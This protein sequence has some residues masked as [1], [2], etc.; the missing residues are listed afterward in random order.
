MVIQFIT[1]Y[2]FTT[3]EKAAEHPAEIVVSYQL[4]H[5]SVEE[6]LG[7]AAEE[8][9]L[10][11]AHDSDS[12]MEAAGDG[13][14]IHVYASDLILMDGRIP[15]E[16]K[17]AV[18]KR[19]RSI[20]R[21]TAPEGTL[22]GIIIHEA[23]RSPRDFI[24]IR[25]MAGE[26]IENAYEEDE[27]EILIIE[28]LFA[29]SS[30][31]RLDTDGREYY[32]VFLDVLS[33]G[34]T[35]M[36]DREPEDSGLDDFIRKAERLDAADALT[37]RILGEICSSA[38]LEFCECSSMPRPTDNGMQTEIRHYSIIGVPG[39]MT[40]GEEKKLIRKLAL[41]ADTAMKALGRGSISGFR[42]E[43]TAIRPVSPPAFSRDA[44]CLADKAAREIAE[45]LPPLRA[46]L[47]QSR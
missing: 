8:L 25:K 4:F 28:G 10:L 24:G 42:A 32:A 2:S 3:E 22:C 36:A 20:I 1:E 18:R 29:E 31:L 5:R 16:R 46:G 13:R 30:A 7:N 43:K 9:G 44:E 37:G 15:E 12:I 39:G 11:Y 14:R 6:R 38:G 34:S 45:P 47:E 17:T 35:G 40:A 27:E 26:N 21:E 33:A 23:E 19:F 41:D